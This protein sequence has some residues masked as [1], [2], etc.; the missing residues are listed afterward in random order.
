MNLSGKL[1]P[2]VSRHNLLFVAGLVWTAA[3]GILLW[4]G[5]SFLLPAADH[6]VL[7]L[8]LGVL[9]GILFYFLLFARISKKHILRILGLA[10]P[11]PCAF[12]FFDIRS[13][14]LMAIMISSGIFLRKLN[15][16]RPDLLYNFFITMSV[17]LL[18]SAARFFK[19]W[20]AK[21][22]LP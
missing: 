14:I 12:S 22:D 6:L 17:P 4:R 10:I 2:S 11:Y 15:V 19:S 9:S 7:R 16:I 8:I 1:K 20:S 13:Y 18:L 21:T 5:L 3:G